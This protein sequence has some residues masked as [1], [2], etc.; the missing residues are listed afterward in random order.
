MHGEFRPD[1]E[2]LGAKQSQ[3]A[4]KSLIKIIEI[5]TLNRLLQQSH[6]S[7]TDAEKGATISFKRMPGLHVVNLWQS[8]ANVDLGFSHR[9]PSFW[10]F[11]KES[12]RHVG[13]RSKPGLSGR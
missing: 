2:S 3:E 8:R 5:G 10:P 12:E 4:L 11:V 9:L 6:R 13:N 7:H 1:H